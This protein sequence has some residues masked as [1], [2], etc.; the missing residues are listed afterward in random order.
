MLRFLG[1]FAFLRRQELGT[2]RCIQNI[3]QRAPEFRWRCPGHGAPD[4][5][6][7]FGIELLTP[8]MDIWSPL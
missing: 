3:E 1:N 5:E 7:R 2:D 8:Y 6:P 4:G